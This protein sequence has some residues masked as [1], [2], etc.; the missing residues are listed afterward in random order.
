[1]EYQLLKRTKFS[2]STPD[3]LAHQ[4]TAKTL[5]K[6]FEYKIALE[7]LLEDYE[8]DRAS[9]EI[10]IKLDDAFKY[11]TEGSEKLDKEEPEEEVKDDKI[12]NF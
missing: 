6:A 7:N 11:V 12:I 4:K 2:G 9:F 1:M 10:C 3:S 8:K 5:K